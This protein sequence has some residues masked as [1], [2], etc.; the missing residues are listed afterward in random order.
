M[1]GSELANGWSPCLTV[2]TRRKEMNAGEK[3]RFLDKDA[4]L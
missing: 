1:V 3:G 4:E 2:Q